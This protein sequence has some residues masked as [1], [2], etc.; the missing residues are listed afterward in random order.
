MNENNTEMYQL[1]TCVVK[2]GN[3]LWVL[4][5]TY[6]SITAEII[7]R[8]RKPLASYEVPIKDFK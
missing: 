1:S 4:E 3:K 2:D 7:R 5:T 6:S 8:T